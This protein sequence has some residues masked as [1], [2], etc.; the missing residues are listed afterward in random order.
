MKILASFQ[1]AI[2]SS[3]PGEEA[4][5]RI[6]HPFYQFL[7]KCQAIDPASSF[8]SEKIPA[9]LP[10]SLT[11]PQVLADIALVGHVDLAEQGQPGEWMA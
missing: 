6:C 11:V 8:H 1:I 2:F 9:G 3:L 10:I 5:C 7:K 4:D